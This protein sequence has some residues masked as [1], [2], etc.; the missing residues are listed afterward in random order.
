MDLKNL[1]LSEAIIPYHPEIKKII[2]VCTPECSDARGTSKL[3]NDAIETVR[4]RHLKEGV[5]PLFVPMNV[6]GS[7]ITADGVAD[8]EKMVEKKAKR[9]IVNYLLRGVETD[10]IFYITGHGD[11]YPKEGVTDVRHYTDIELRDQKSNINCGMRNMPALGN[12]TEL[13][14]LAKARAEGQVVF[15]IGIPGNV[16][17]YAVRNFNDLRSMMKAVY[18]HDSGPASWALHMG[19]IESH[20]YNQMIVLERKIKES[21]ILRTLQAKG[22]CGVEN[23][24]DMMLYPTHG[25]TD[26]EGKLI[27]TPYDDVFGE[28]ARMIRENPELLDGSEHAADQT[29]VFGFI[30]QTDLPIKYPKEMVYNFLIDPTLEANAVF[31]QFGPNKMFNISGTNISNPTKILLQPK[32]FAFTY[33]TG[34][35][36]LNL[37]VWPVLTD[38]SLDTFSTIVRFTMSN[39]LTQFDCRENQVKFLPLSIKDGEVVFV[40]PPKHSI[41]DKYVADRAMWEVLRKQMGEARRAQPIGNVPAAT[42]VPQKTIH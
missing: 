2:V 22:Y 4:E 11:V 40:D 42:K 41:I 6:A 3:K 24:K 10:F 1:E 25:K 30:F 7:Y 39:P 23:Y 29:P 20:S 5:L 28:M 19:N 26:A 27:R 17:Q 37:R 32:A 36:H 21:E 33:G 38:S 35:E 8:I 18:D 34:R 13:K 16:R 31:G 15:D 14:I 12:E 9:R